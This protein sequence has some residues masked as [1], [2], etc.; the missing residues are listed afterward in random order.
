MTLFILEKVRRCD[1][2]LSKMTLYYNTFRQKNENTV[3][4]YTMSVNSLDDLRKVVMYDHV[5]A[6]YQDN[7]RKISSF[8]QAN[9][10]M[11][12]V[13]NTD[14]DDSTQWITPENV[15][16]AFNDVPF[17]VVF[18]KNHM[19]EKNGKA[20]R[21]KF[22]V[23]FP[24]ITINNSEMYK[25][26]KDKVCKYFTA[27]DF[28]A[29][30]TARFF[31]GVENPQP[32][33]FE[34]N[35]LLSDFMN[36]IT[37]NEEEATAIEPE[38]NHTDIIQ[39]GSRN[40]TL[41]RFAT[42]KL[43]RLGDITNEA[44]QAF[45]IESSKCLPP[46]DEKELCSIWKSALK[47][48]NQKVKSSSTYIPP[49]QYDNLSRAVPL[50]PDDFTDIGQ[51]KVFSC[52]YGEILRFSPFTKFLYYTG[53]VW[54]ENDLKTHGLAQQL[55]DRQLKDAFAQLDEAQKEENIAAVNGDKAKQK[56]AKD[57]IRKATKYRSF[58]LNNRHTLRITAVL[59]EVQPMLEIDISKL[60]AD[61][62]LL[63]TPKGTVDLR[64][65]DLNSHMPLDYCTKITTVSPEDEGAELFKSF[66]QTITCG[67]QDLEEYLQI[68]AG[69]CSI[70]KVY[71]ENLIIAY[72]S[73][74]NGK[75]TFFNLL[76][77]IMGG[78]SGNLSAEVFTA[79]CRKNKSPEY[80]ELR[81]KRLV[82]AS[83]LEEETHLNTAIVKQLCSTDSIYA[84][85]KY[86]APFQFTPS[87]TTILCTNH[88]PRVN[89]LDSGTWR[90]LIVVPFNAVIEQQEE[91]KNYADYLYEKAGGAILSWI[92]KGAVK[93]INMNY[94]IVLPQAVQQSI[95]EYRMG[96]DW[97]KNF[98]YECCEIDKSFSEKAGELY[99]GYRK[100]CIRMGE[101]AKRS[102][103]FKKAL[104]E[105][106]YRTKR[107][108]TGNFVYGL[109]LAIK[110][111]EFQ[112]PYVSPLSVLVCDGQDE[113]SSKEQ[114]EF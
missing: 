10:S 77:R 93:Y 99:Q 59:K 113:I 95:E 105:A 50:K 97:L 112:M 61:G 81:G 11:F 30:D 55:T 68:V 76:S 13:D 75:S 9:C 12:D 31:H 37:Y 85:K 100:Y 45:K 7:R 72:G 101:S 32:L 8:I 47:F 5:C 17:W 71:S 18:S 20:P 6:K 42:R 110:I 22:H 96:N 48:Y 69:M 108:N 41:Y 1:S 83:E 3:Y 80:A 38:S 4:P 19:K 2:M 65:G 94:K 73:G 63:N 21:P 107:K 102:D 15:K 58:I 89:T 66:L 26:L 114:V 25:N 35:T 36:K 27:F 49:E 39:E 56:D 40:T 64:T 87:H 54:I 84:E 51:A 70:G 79:N 43:V 109:R 88:L 67:N 28:N 111:P 104:E 29:R 86:K 91:I 33:F 46:L 106:G 98:T 34:G 57:R 92:I 82:I 60:D 16:K 44:Y 62:F 14:S 103:S 90:R 23:Y 78:Y 53:K 24:D 74:K 52:E